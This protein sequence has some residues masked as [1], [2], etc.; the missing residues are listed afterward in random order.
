[1]ARSKV[2]PQMRT[3]PAAVIRVYDEPDNVI[4]MHEHNGDFKEW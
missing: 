2:S 3:A 1:M 4:T